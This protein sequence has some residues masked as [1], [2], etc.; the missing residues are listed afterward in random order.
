[1]NDNFPTLPINELNDNYVD[2]ISFDTIVNWPPRARYSIQPQN[3]G[4]KLPPKCYVACF[5]SYY[6]HFFILQHIFT[7]MSINWFH[8][9]AYPI[10]LRFFVIL[11]GLLNSMLQYSLIICVN[12]YFYLY[13]KHEF[14]HANHRALS[15]ETNTSCMNAALWCQVAVGALQLLTPKIHE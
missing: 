12:S 5:Y 7:C 6:T 1:M 15:I 10:S 11:Y 4:R 2:S 3:F 14:N 13:S 9:H 8:I